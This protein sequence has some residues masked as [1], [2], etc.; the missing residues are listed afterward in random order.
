MTVISIF[1]Q[2]TR[3]SSTAIVNKGRARN[4][5]VND[6]FQRISLI[7]FSM[8]IN[9]VPIYVESSSNRA[10]PL[11]RGVLDSPSSKLNFN[12]QLPTELDR[13]LRPV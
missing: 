2:T 4:V 13:F 11:S 12:L 6:S 8:N 9:L 3:T 1:I 10:D 5:A 7:L